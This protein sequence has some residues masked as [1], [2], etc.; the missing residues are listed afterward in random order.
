MPDYPI[1][2]TEYDN[3]LRAYYCQSALLVD[4]LQACLAGHS[5]SDK[6]IPKF[7]FGGYPQTQERLHFHFDKDLTLQE[8]LR[9]GLVKFWLEPL[10]QN[11]GRV[12][13]T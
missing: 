1:D 6:E 10:G 13:S 8:H 5:L 12:Q 2:T 3:S 11:S 7:L 9:G 4:S